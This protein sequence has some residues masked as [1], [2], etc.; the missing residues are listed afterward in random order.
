VKHKA[1][2]VIVFLL[3]LGLLVASVF[4]AQI[5]MGIGVD[6]TGVL[7][8]NALAEISFGNLIDLRGQL[9]IV[10]QNVAGLLML[11][12]AVLVHQPFPP[13]DPYLGGGIGLAFAPGFST[14]FTVEGLLGTRIGLLAPV[15]AFIELRYVV[16]YSEIGWTAGPLFEG[17]LLLSF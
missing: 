4:A 17:G 15:A 6:P 7:L 14:G 1:Q 2:V 5:G 11:G 16:R 12:G 10:T 13:L 3:L 9:G 8:V